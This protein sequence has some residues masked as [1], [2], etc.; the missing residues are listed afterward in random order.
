[1]TGL[2]RRSFLCLG[3]GAVAWMGR[4]ATSAATGGEPD[5]PPQVALGPTGI[6]CS[7]LA[8]GTGTHGGN[9]QSDQTRLGFEK[10]VRLVQ[11][12]YERGITFLDLADLYGSHVYIREALRSI[13]RDKVTI[14]TKLWWRYDGEVRGVAEPYRAKTAKATIE[15]FLHELNTDYLDMCL[16]HCVTTATW[17]R[18]L[19]PYMDAL[20]ELKDKK[21]IRALGVSCHD[22]GA[23]RTAAASPWVDVILARINPR[24]VKMDG[25]PQQ[26]LEVLRTAKANGKVVVGMKIFGEGELVREL[27]DCMRFAQSIGVLDAMTIGFVA[28]G[29]VDETLRLMARYPVSTS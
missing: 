28:P 27:D 20:S 24:G 12:A 19:K 16:L 3:A 26:I 23:L 22:Y 1:M 8:I 9:R 21:V 17:D 10:L 18:E 14:L 13:P 5:A 6:R 4:R 25:T 15:R 2:D 11:H 29:E 7:R